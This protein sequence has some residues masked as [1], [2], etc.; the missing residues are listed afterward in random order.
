MTDIKKII[1][2]ATAGVIVVILLVAAIIASTAN[3]TVDVGLRRPDETAT[4]SSET[5]ED[6]QQEYDEREQ[7]PQTIVESL[8]D[9]AIRYLSLGDFDGLDSRLATM[10]ATYKETDD[11]ALA[12][13]DEIDRYRADLAYTKAISA[14]GS[15]A[16]TQW[17]FYNPEFLAAAVAYTPISM[18]YQAMI[19]HESAV[20]AP[21][22]SNISLRRSDMTEEELRSVLDTINQTRSGGNEFQMVTVYEMNVFGYDCEFIAVSDIQSVTWQPYSLNVKNDPEFSVTAALCYELL[23]QNPRTNLDAILA[24]TVAS[25]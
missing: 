4:P 5:E 8:D 13:I 6:R 24:F 3:Q 20:M 15:N 1:A 14:F 22:L 9:I 23:E 7:L 21:A 16:V 17:R 2:V 11:D 10:I 12:V 19:S 25:V 18:K